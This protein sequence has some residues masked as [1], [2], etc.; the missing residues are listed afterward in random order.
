MT[1]GDGLRS[2]RIGKKGSGRPLHCGSGSFEGLSLSLDV[3]RTCMLAYLEV[4]DAGSW[5]LRRS[6]W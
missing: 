5:R 4:R 1:R 2:R 6:G 3:D